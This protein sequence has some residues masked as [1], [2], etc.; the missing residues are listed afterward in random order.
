M[1]LLIN[2]IVSALVILVGAYVVPGVHVDGFVTALVAAVILGIL[3]AI[4]KPILLVLTLPINILTLGL[5]TLVINAVVILLV[6]SFVPG[7]TVD[8]LGWAILYSIVI[9]VISSFLLQVSR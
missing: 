4:V 8:G 2:W 5:F 6:T 1:S 3:N 7:F 9:S